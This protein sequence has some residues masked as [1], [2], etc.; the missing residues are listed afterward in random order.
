MRE[1][2]KLRTLVLDSLWRNPVVGLAIYD[3]AQQSLKDANGAFLE[4]LDSRLR[5]KK[6]LGM[7][8]EQCLPEFDLSGLRSI[9]ERVLQTGIAYH[10]ESLRLQR[11]QLGSTT[12]SCSIL[13]VVTGEEHEPGESHLLLLVATE[14]KSQLPKPEQM[15]LL[16]NHTRQALAR[17]F[18]LSAREIDIVSECLQGKKN[19]QIATDLHIGISTVKRH[20][21]SAYRKMGISSSRS[22]PLS[23]LQVVRSLGEAPAEI[24]VLNPATQRSQA[25]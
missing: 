8:M 9:C 22:L 14:R 11:S 6:T 16:D 24:S 17:Q 2:G 23:I 5:T 13:P 3:A 1:N 15:N 21:E 25:A 7:P 18:H 19:R 12:V 10:T 4:L 20:L